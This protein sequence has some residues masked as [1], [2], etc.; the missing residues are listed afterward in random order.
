MFSGTFEKQ[1]LTVTPR[2]IFPS[3]AAFWASCLAACLQSLFPR[4]SLSV[5]VMRPLQKQGG[6]ADVQIF[7]LSRHCD[8]WLRRAG[9]LFFFFSLAS[10]PSGRPSLKL[11]SG[12]FGGVPPAPGGGWV[13]A[14]KHVHKVP[15]P[16]PL[17]RQVASC[18]WQ[19]RQESNWHT[20]EWWE[21]VPED[22][23][24]SGY[25]SL[26]E[27]RRGSLTALWLDLIRH[28]EGI[29]C[30]LGTGNSCLGHD[31]AQ[32]RELTV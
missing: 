26:V 24:F 20:L 18:P 5:G 8:T 1:F 28:S 25:L 31:A 32:N 7:S 19:R 27:S 29:S 4:P 11:R 3:P 13:D 14:R 2:F 17:T 16:P 12:R 30:N 15:A 9:L 6:H 10:P 21:A 23:L 22:G